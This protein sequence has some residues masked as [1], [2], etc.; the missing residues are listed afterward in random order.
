MIEI[1]DTV[2][3]ISSGE[4]RQVTGTR[5][6]NMFTTQVGMD[7][8]TVWHHKESELEL[9]AKAPKP[10]TEPGFVPSRGIMD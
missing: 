3:V 7:G 2:K 8:A 5:D 10:K 6:P 1:G 4:I 9:V